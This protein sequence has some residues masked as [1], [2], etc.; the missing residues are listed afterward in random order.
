MALIPPFFSDCVVAIGYEVPGQGTIWGASGFFYFHTLK[1]DQGRVYLVTNKHVLNGN[2]RVFLR[3]NPKALK[4]PKGYELNLKDNQTGNLLWRGHYLKDV[5]VAVI[6]VNF[7]LF[8][9]EDMQVSYFHDV[10]HTL[11][12]KDMEN[13]G[14]SE[15]DRLFAL[16][17]PVSLVGDKSSTA[18]VRGGTLARIR[19]T[20][21]KPTEPYLIDSTVFP[22]NSG[23]PVVNSP[24]LVSIEGTKTINRSSLIGIVASY[25]PYRDIA[26]SRQ[27]RNVRVVFEENSGLSN[28]FSVD[29]IRT[30][31]N[32]FERQ[33]K[34]KIKLATPKPSEQAMEQ[35]IESSLLT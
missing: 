25:V 21:K 17:F 14:I 23:G 27:T 16:G 32:S 22:G 18:I 29:C 31:I 11:D 7:P 8:E 13:E 12:V 19:D 3:L 15:G 24:E 2:D 26:V 6:P 5:D 35:P 30:T 33:L 20:F 4:E 10:N 1:G 9:K 28:V 34:Q